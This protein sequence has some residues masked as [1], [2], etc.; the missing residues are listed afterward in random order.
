MV[1]L[2]I[3][4]LRSWPI[5][6]IWYNHISSSQVFAKLWDR[7]NAETKLLN[8]KVRNM[9]SLP[10]FGFPTFQILSVSYFH[11]SYLFNFIHLIWQFS[12]Y[13]LNFLLTFSSSRY[14][15]ITRALFPCVSI[16]Q[17]LLPKQ[18]Y[19]FGVRKFNFQHMLERG[20]GCQQWGEGIKA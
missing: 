3:R 20:Q 11:F 1:I 14:C 8:I 4:I 6:T 19:I 5:W 13:F 17:Y 9:T 15:F 18:G 2:S 10:K 12:W 16:S 7:L